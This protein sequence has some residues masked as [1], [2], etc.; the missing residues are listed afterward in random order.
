[1][2]RLAAGLDP[3][4]YR[5]V[6]GLFRD[7]WLRKICEES[8]IETSILRMTGKLDLRWLRRFCLFARRQNVKLIHAHEFGANTYGALAAWVLGIPLIATVHGRHYYADRLRRR[9][10][11]RIVSHIAT[12]VAVSE[13]VK[14]FLV[15]TTGVAERRI[16]VVYNGVG[17]L[18][19]LPA[20]QV[21]RRRSALGIAGDQRIV[22]VVGSLYGVKG[23]RYL[24][25]AA[26]QILE[27]CPSAIF[28]IVGC[29]ELE[30]DLK[31]QAKRLGLDGRVRFL[32][33]REDVGELLSLFDVFALPSLSEGLSLAILEAMAAGRPVVATNVGGNPELIV[34][35]ETGV[36]VPAGDVRNLAAAIARLL[37]DTAEARRLGENGMDR[38]KRCFALESMIEGYQ[39]IY[40]HELERAGVVG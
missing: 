9:F 15:R 32:G 25:E 1:M 3:S 14:R 28:L 7:G 21:W 23:H 33:F 26:R 16:R 10:V 19:P 29:G 24:L 13:D 5:S 38:V 27:A 30:A 22:G 36:L 40:D 34:D 37:T 39:A 12:M 4:R 20:H 35:G 11:C 31:A 2:A 18:A 8:G 17:G 6:A